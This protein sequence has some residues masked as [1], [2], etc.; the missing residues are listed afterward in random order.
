MKK[1]LFKGLVT[2][3]CLIS[4]MSCNKT[5]DGVKPALKQSLSVSQLNEILNNN[6]EFQ[7]F[8]SWRALQTKNLAK[9]LS[10]IKGNDKILLDALLKKYTSHELLF[11]IATNEEKAQVSSILHLNTK[12]KFASPL[13]EVL[14]NLK[15]KYNFS[16]GDFLSVLKSYKLQSSSNLRNATCACYSVCQTGGMGVWNRV[17]NTNFYDFGADF[18]VSVAYADAA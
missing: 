3:L 15:D 17:F 7:K 11:S 12:Y 14:S 18:E 5:Q 1:L 8:L 9:T 13:R 4:I 2:L 6:S 16:S 10:S